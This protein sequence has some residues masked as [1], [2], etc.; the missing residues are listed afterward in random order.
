MIRAFFVTLGVLAAIM[1]IRFLPLI[2]AFIWVIL[3]SKVFWYCVLWL[4]ALLAAITGLTPLGLVAMVISVL[5]VIR[6]VQKRERAEIEA[7]VR[8]YNAG[9]NK[10]LA[11]Q[12][13]LPFK[14]GDR[15]TDDGCEITCCLPRTFTPVPKMTP[16]QSKQFNEV[17]NQ[18]LT[19]EQQMNKE[20]DRLS[21]MRRF[22]PEV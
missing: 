11:P 20:W 15:F 3:T 19:P 13:P 7:R 4:V 5:F 6:G 8:D 10:P 18:R 14:V 21:A 9:R 12:T 1:F 2:V 22:M 17:W 16:E